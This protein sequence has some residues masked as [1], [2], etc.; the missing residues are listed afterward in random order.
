MSFY[1]IIKPEAEQDLLDSSQWYEEQKEGLGL[2]F[3]NS[4]EDKLMS[5]RKTPLHYQ[6]K[7][8]ATRLAL[9]R[10]F[11]Y[12]IH[13]TV[14]GKT[15]YVLAILSTSRNPRIWESRSK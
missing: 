13:F 6:I 15:I 1:L 7:Y 4:V 5:I 3:I 12:A 14:E 10:S 11:P 8:K 9:V 2:R